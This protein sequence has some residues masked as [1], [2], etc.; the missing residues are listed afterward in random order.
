MVGDL[1]QQAEIE[2]DDDDSSCYL[3]L[4]NKSNFFIQKE[5]I[6]NSLGKIVAM[7]FQFE[8]LV[9]STGDVFP[10]LYISCK[11]I[12]GRCNFVGI[13][14]IEEL[15]LNINTD[16]LLKVP[17]ASSYTVYD[18]RKSLDNP[19]YIQLMREVPDLMEYIN[20]QD[21]LNS[22]PR[23]KASDLTSYPSNGHFRFGFF[24]LGNFILGIISLTPGA[25]TA[26]TPGAETA[27]FSK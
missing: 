22:L 1:P 8:P 6:K 24:V 19:R 21:R 11:F 18:F 9:A 15:I 2:A 17:V 5:T 16:L 13:T 26:L 3:F 23:R 10:R 14:F 20:E 12:D 27:L 25:E 4:I 7:A